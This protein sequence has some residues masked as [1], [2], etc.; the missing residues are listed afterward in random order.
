MRAMGYIID[1]KK[2]D[3]LLQHSPLR[4]LHFLL[5]SKFLGILCVMERRKR[6]GDG[7]ESESEVEGRELESGKNGTID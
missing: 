7:R 6:G 3:S 5:I 1:P 2:I 4:K